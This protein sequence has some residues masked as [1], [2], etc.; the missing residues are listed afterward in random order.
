[1][2]CAVDAR[3]FAQRCQH[4]VEKAAEVEQAEGHTSRE[5]LVEYD[6][7]R[8]LV[9][10]GDAKVKAV[11][12]ECVHVVWCDIDIGCSDCGPGER[13]LAGLDNLVYVWWI[14]CFDRIDGA[15]WR[16][17]WRIYARDPVGTAWNKTSCI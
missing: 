4:V 3:D 16:V 9:E 11:E 5:D 17:T 2:S 10:L 6:L 14:E 13:N 1:M 7:G 12:S 15:E 8:A